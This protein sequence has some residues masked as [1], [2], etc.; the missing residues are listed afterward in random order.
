MLRLAPADDEMRAKVERPAFFGKRAA[1]H[2][3]GT[4]L[5]ERAFAEIGKFF[6]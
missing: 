3:F 6:V 1:I 2:Q 4:G 5:G